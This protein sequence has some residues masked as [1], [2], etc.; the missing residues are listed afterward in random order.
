MRLHQRA[1]ADHFPLID[2]FS[3]SSKGP[4]F[5][6]CARAGE[7]PG[8]VGIGHNTTIRCEHES[9]EDVNDRSKESSSLPRPLPEKDRD[10]T[11]LWRLYMYYEARGPGKFSS[12]LHVRASR[13]IVRLLIVLLIVL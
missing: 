3:G 9:E 4:C 6:K 8:K 1:A 5:R 13:H 11:V 10:R 2:C 12:S 7:T